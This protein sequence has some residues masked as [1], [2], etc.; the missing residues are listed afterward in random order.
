LR[1]EKERVES[2]GNRGNVKVSGGI[3]MYSGLYIY[4]E[5]FDPSLIP[6]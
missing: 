2:L 4:M 3:S 6:F 5:R 1:A